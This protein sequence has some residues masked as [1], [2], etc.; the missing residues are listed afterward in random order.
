MILPRLTST[1]RGPCRT[2]LGLSR[3]LEKVPRR[4]GVPVMSMPARQSG[5]TLTLPRPSQ[6]EASETSSGTLSTAE[7]S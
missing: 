4:W 2:G 1:Q 6:S 5:L 3:N 7:G